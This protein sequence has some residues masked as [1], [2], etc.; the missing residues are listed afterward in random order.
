MRPITKVVFVALLLSMTTVPESSGKIFT[1]CGLLN[2]LLRL[3]V[4]RSF[5][6]NWICLVRS[7]S[8]L[9]T[10]AVHNKGSGHNLGLFQLNDKIY[11]DNKKSGG[12][13]NI[14]CAN[15]INDDIS[16][17]LQCAQKVHA[18]KGWQAWP[19]WE[20]NCKQRPSATTMPLC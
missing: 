9:N 15:F 7:E 3:G 14:R 2:E 6:G 1:Q 13:C 12:Q 18:E 8:Y 17:D 16:D 4:H 11:C 10:S 5:V 19:G 20:R